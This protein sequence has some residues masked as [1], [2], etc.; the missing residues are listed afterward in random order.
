MIAKIF[1]KTGDDAIVFVDADGRRRRVALALLAEAAARH[2]DA[3]KTSQ[4]RWDLI[5]DQP[6]DASEPESPGQNEPA[7]AIVAIEPAGADFFL[8]R[9]DAGD[10]LRLAA[11]E[12]QTLIG[13]NDIRNAKLRGVPPPLP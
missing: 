8:A 4:E 3:L 11:S 2:G 10:E 1:P 7:D 5:D 6:R 13:A 12:L 9:T